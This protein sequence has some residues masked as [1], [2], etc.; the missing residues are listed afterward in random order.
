MIFTSALL[1]V[2]L[3]INNPVPTVHFFYVRDCGHCMDIL[4]GDIPRLQSK[5]KF[6]FRKYDIDIMDNYRLLEKMEQNVKNIGEDLPVIFVNDSVF[7]GPLETREKLEPTLKIYAKN[8]VHVII[9]DTTKI[10][11]DTI[12][13]DTLVSI[14]NPIHLYYFYQPGCQGCDRTEILLTH[15]QQRHKQLVIH[16]HDILDDSN[17]VF[18]EALAQKLG[19]PDR[20]RLVV[21]TIIVGD[22]YLLE[23]EINLAN[24]DSLSLQYKQG[25]TDYKAL[26]LDRAEKNIVERFAR[27]SIFGIMFAGLLDGVN[28]C[29]FATLIFFVS[30]LLFIGRRRKDI[31]VMSLFFIFAVFISYFAIGLG[32]YSLLKYLSGYAFISKLIFLCFGIIALVLGVLS[33]RDFFLARQGKLDKMILQL[34][35][36]IKQRIHKSIKKKTAI[37]SI[38]IGSLIAGFLISYL[39]FGCTGQ[40]YLPTITFMISK[41]GVSLKPLISL[42]LYNLMF[43]LPLIIIAIIASLFSTKKIGKS[44][45]T[46]TPTIKLLT[47][48]LF[49]ALG[50][51]LILSA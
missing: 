27:F 17:K 41:A 6:Q 50:I 1:G 28:P 32:A 25:S 35:L 37:S 24:L 29:A 26:D 43:I 9:K 46:K 5:Y 34:P 23:Q 49:F 7:Y 36:G 42:L 47:A 22:S 15:S 45:E 21:P 39:E 19:I 18:F 11:P 33:L 40:V 44:L 14:L 31:I 13:T 16:R 38:I 2:F 51:L 4:L 30:Y 3:L 12:S 10:P 48:I 20:A 8:S